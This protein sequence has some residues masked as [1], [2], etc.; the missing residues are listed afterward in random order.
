[1]TGYAEEYKKLPNFLALA[2]MYAG[3]T[4]R[5]VTFLHPGNKPGL[6]NA[7]LVP[8]SCEQGGVYPTHL[9]VSKSLSGH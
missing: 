5:H 3:V 1:M 2:E 8:R 9:C 7:N 4:C 6:V